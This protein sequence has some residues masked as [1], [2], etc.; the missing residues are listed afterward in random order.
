MNPLIPSLLDQGDA[1]DAS[2]RAGGTRRRSKTSRQRLII[3][4][5]CRT[6]RRSRSTPAAWRRSAIRR[7]VISQYA[8]YVPIPDADHFSNLDPRHPAWSAVLDALTHSL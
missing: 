8:T 2:G 7:V 1:V 6:T 5:H 3:S 4:M